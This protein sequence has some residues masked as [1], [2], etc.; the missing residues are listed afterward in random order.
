MKH[1]KLSIAILLLILGGQAHAAEANVDAEP[2]ASAEAQDADA[3][4]ALET[5][6]KAKVIVLDEQTHKMKLRQDVLDRLEAE[7]KLEKT[8]SAASIFCL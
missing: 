6:A 2:A 8:Y 7:G 5:L 3:V 4:R 1:E